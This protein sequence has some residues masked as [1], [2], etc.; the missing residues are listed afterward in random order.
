VHNQPQFLL[1]LYGQIPPSTLF[2]PFPFSL[3]E[4]RRLGFIVQGNKRFSR[5]SLLN[6]PPDYI[7]EWL[8]HLACFLQTSLKAKAMLK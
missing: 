8:D 7:G 3:A 2:S 5:K 1:P 6:F 4:L